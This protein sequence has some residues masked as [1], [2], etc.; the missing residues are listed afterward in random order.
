MAFKKYFLTNLVEANLIEALALLLFFLI[1][2]AMAKDFDPQGG[3]GGGYFKST[4]PA[5][6]Y[7]IGTNGRYGFIVNN[8]SL[9]CGAIN[10]DGSIGDIWQDTAVHGGGGGS[11]LPKTSCD[12]GE[13]INAMGLLTGD[14]SDN[15]VIRQIIFNCVSTTSTARHNL[16]IGT[17]PLFPTMQQNCEAGEA[18]VGIQGRS[19]SYLDAAGLLCGPIVRSPP[20]PLGLC[21][22]GPAHPDDRP[23]QLHND[24]SIWVCA[25]QRN[26]CLG[27]WNML[28]N[29]RTTVQI[30]SYCEL[31]Q[32]LNNGSIL[33]YTGQFSHCT[34]TPCPNWSQ[35]DGNPQTKTIAVSAAYIDPTNNPPYVYQMHKDGSIWHQ[36]GGGWDMI[37]NNPATTA[38]VGGAGGLYQLHNDSKVYHW[39][40]NCA[41]GSPG[42][43]WTLLDQSPDPTIMIT[44]GNG[45]YQLRK[46][47]AILHRHKQRVHGGVMFEFVVTARPGGR[48]YVDDQSRLQ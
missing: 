48:N 23:Y 34:S 45:L 6:K 8:I 10:W 13:I 16:D 27:A 44:A 29:N 9:I 37:D 24:G 22:S 7:L 18:V 19:G 14:A 42:C 4:C 15:K 35:I 5:G 21:S 33:H 32:M 1:S 40:A 17:A 31:Y 25:G 39:N 38:I 30:A 3:A 41:S 12:S 2:P 36:N 11:P 47:G 20:P 28:D 43:P 46:S 26:A